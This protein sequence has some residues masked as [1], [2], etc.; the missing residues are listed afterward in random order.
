MF[1]QLTAADRMLFQHYGY[2]RAGRPEFTRIHHAVEAQARNH[3][4]LTAV[5][6][7]G[8]RLT[9]QELDQQAEQLANR[10]ALLG[11]R[12]GDRVG[13]FLTRSPQLVVGILAVL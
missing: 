3:P 7:L 4:R 13:L 1:D 12:A 8:V 5:E 10:L 6:H 11:V 2:G 9:Y